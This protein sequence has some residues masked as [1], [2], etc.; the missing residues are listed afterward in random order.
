VQK[1]VYDEVPYIHVGKFSALAA[2]SP[3]LEGFAPST[4]PCFWNVRL[5]S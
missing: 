5:K 1:L 4:W 2:R 3:A